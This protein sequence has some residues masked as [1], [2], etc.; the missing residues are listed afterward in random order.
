MH[1]STIHVSIGSQ[2]S[3]HMRIAL[4]AAGGDHAPSET[5]KGAIKA[6]HKCRA[7]ILLVGPPEQL[8]PEIH[9]YGGL[10]SNVRLV[11]SD[12]ALKEGEPATHALRRRSNCSVA[13]ATRLV[14][15]GEADAMISAGS[16][17]AAS[18][19]A[20]YYLGMLPGIGRPAVCVPLVGLAP[21]TVLID[22]GANV[23]CK[24]NH[25]LSFGAI[26]TVYARRM[27]GV[28]N[29]KVALLSTGTEQGKGP[30]TLQESYT[31]LSKSGLNFVGNVEGYD[32]LSGKANVIVC[33]GIVG[34]ILLKFYESLGPRFTDWMKD[35]SDGR[36]I[37]GDGR[38]MLSRLMHFTRLTRAESTGG[39][40]LWGVNGV[41]Q[42][43]HGNSTAPHFERAISR[44]LQAANANVVNELRA[45]F[46]AVQERCRDYLDSAPI[47]PHE[48]PRS[49]AIPAP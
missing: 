24:P 7:H 2:L 27:L 33:D 28:P 26:G 22:G 8:E 10:P 13:V 9:R 49:F 4:D 16:T 38:R 14:R 48:S 5:V 46:A 43:M 19:S 32:V 15:D 21:R 18:V 41:V 25:M 23:D 30:R 11:P 44:A 40:L 47:T 36:P 42:I 31:L 20:I 6:A 37:V 29:P 12:E 17:G 3:M 35:R 39:G 1:A 34:N 45:E